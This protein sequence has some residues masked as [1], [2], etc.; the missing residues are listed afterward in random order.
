M[1]VRRKVALIYLLL[2]VLV[3]SGIACETEEEE[4]TPK[5]TKT[6]TLKSEPEETTTTLE[7]PQVKQEGEIATVTRVI[8]G[9]TI[10][11]TFEDGRVERVRYIGID[12]PE[13]YEDLSREAT[14]ANE[15]LVAGKKVRLK[16]DVSERDKYGRLLRYVYVGSLFVNAELVRQDYAAVATYPPDVKYADLFVRL[17][18]EA[19]EKQVGL[20]APKKERA[21]EP[22]RRGQFVGNKRSKKL[23]NLAHSSCQYYVSLM[24][25]ANKVFFNSEQEAMDAG[26]Y[27][28]KRCY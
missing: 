9:D 25:E 16:R 19:R 17:Q 4:T 28:C 27:P 14:E 21:V 2:L 20:W 23:H 12:T 6:T 7:E 10:E 13:R 18:R 1:K 22:Q 26:Y 15:R 8:D 24:S 11:V 3:F 5:T